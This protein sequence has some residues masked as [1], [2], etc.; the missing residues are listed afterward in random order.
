MNY[1][2]NMGIPDDLLNKMIEEN[3]KAKLRAL[4][5]EEAKAQE[6]LDFIRQEN[7]EKEYCL[8]NI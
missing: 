4:D 3:I 2:N 8:K 7:I 6:R 5:E 1:T